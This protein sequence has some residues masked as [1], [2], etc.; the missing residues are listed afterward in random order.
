MDK[1]VQIVIELLAKGFLPE[2]ISSMFSIGIGTVQHIQ[3]Q[4][5][6]EIL[7]MSVGSEIAAQGIDAKIRRAEDIAIDKLTNAL[8]LESDIS[9]ITHAFKVVN[10]AKRIND[11]PEKT[12]GVKFATIQV[13]NFIQN[14]ISYQKDTSGQIVAAGNVQLESATQDGVESLLDAQIEMENNLALEA[15]QMFEGETAD[16]LF[17]TVEE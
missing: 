15:S 11:K 2:K 10:G 3:E 4:H 16:E 1:N 17:G 13:N 8:A 7:E 12:E 6:A 14:K 9:K 5:K